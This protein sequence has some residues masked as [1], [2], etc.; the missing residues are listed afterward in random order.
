MKLNTSSTH[1][2]ALW[3]CHTRLGNFCHSLFLF[4]PLLRVSLTTTAHSETRSQQTTPPAPRQHHPSAEPCTR[5]EQDPTP[6]QTV[7]LLMGTRARDS[8]TVLLRDEETGSQEA[9]ST[10]GDGIPTPECHART[11]RG[12]SVL[13]KSLWPHSAL[14]GL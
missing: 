10:P 9:A 8:T 1:V 3:N 4:L 6:A 13:C 11:A 14:L 2:F 5:G 12:E 7:G